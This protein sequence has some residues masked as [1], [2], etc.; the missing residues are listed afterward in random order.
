HSTQ[1]GPPQ[2]SALTA[3]ALHGA[4]PSRRWPTL[5]AGRRG[6]DGATRKAILI[7]HLTTTGRKFV[8]D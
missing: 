6:N 2:T 8:T 1:L 5:I 3:L 4:G 7:M